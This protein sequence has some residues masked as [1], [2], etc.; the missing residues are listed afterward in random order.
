[1]NRGENESNS[2]PEFEVADVSELARVLELERPR[3]EQMLELRLHPRVAGRIDAEDILQDTFLEASRRL[4]E[5]HRSKPFSSLFLWLRFLAVQRLHQ[6]HRRHFG[7]HRDAARE[8][9]IFRS[10]IPDASSVVLAARLVGHFT[11]PSNA[12]AR[13]ESKLRLE[14]AINRMKPL[15]REILALRHYEGL[16]S[17]EAAQVLELEEDTARKR[18]LRALRRLSALIEDGDDA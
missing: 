1:M 9:S 6:E 13:A 7:A 4:E 11:S 12:A 18:Y 5:F 14:D 10:G 2:K 15:D 17:V 8:V 3:L 16:T